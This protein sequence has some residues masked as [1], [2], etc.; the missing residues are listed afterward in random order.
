MLPRAENGA[1]TR[2]KIS[3]DKQTSVV[4]LS[5]ERSLLHSLTTLYTLLYSQI[6]FQFNL[7]SQLQGLT[8]DVSDDEV[9]QFQSNDNPNTTVSRRLQT[10]SHPDNTQRLVE[11]PKKYNLGDEVQAR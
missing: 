11:A 7:A 4:T 5:G 8:D 10:L 2:Y 1:E 6:T 3:Y 9:G